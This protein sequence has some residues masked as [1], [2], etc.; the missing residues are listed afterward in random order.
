MAEFIDAFVIG[1]GE[2]VR[3]GGPV[4]VQA[5]RWP[6]ARSWPARARARHLCALGLHDAR[7][8][9][10]AGPVRA[11]GFR[12][13]WSVYTANSRRAY[14]PAAVAMVTHDR[15]HMRATRGCRFCQRA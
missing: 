1:D 15:S 12:L 8:R 7:S 4:A 6:R 3:G 13:E 11:P 14:W 9:G 5:E 2:E 10:L